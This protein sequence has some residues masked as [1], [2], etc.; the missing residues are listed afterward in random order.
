M[1]R[2]SYIRSLFFIKTYICRWTLTKKT[3]QEVYR[4]SGMIKHQKVA[5]WV[6]GY[7]QKNS[8]FW[9]CFLLNNNSK[10]IFYFFIVPILKFA[11][12]EAGLACPPCLPL[13]AL[14]PSIPQR[15]IIA[16]LPPGCCDIQEV[17]L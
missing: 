13:K 10:Q 16:F 11:S 7:K 15:P 8:H 3:T 12:S 2:Y 5:F 17:T 1:P 14:E 4:F 6:M 9:G